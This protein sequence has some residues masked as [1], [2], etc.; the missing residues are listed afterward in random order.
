[1]DFSSEGCSRCGRARVENKSQTCELELIT[2]DPPFSGLQ[3]Y[4]EPF[5]LGHV[6]GGHEGLWGLD[7]AQKARG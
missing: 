4:L 7:Y 5:G 3:W 1:M 6:E 2:V